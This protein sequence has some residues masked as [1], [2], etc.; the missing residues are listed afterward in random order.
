MALLDDYYKPEALAAELGI[1][2][3]TLRKLHER[4]EAPAKTTIGRLV[5]YRRES[6]AEWLREREQGRPRKGRR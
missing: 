4:D 5:L 3:R 6:V 1:N 2:V